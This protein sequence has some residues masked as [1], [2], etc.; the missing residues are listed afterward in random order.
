MRTRHG[1]IDDLP[2]YVS[3]IGDSMLALHTPTAQHQAASKT[4]PYLNALLH[5]T[6]AAAQTEQY[7]HCGDEITNQCI[8]LDWVEQTACR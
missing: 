5:E 3:R 6:K 1:A 7:S 4:Q 8:Y 2:R